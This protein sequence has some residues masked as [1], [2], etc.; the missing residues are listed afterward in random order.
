MH[1]ISFVLDKNSSSEFFIKF[2][3]I[4]SV[5]IFEDVFYSSVQFKVHLVVKCTKILIQLISI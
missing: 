1:I 3:E 4:Y 5:L 2:L